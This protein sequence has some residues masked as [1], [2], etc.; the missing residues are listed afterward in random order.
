MGLFDFVVDAGKKLGL[1][2]GGSG[3]ANPAK[4]EATASASLIKEIQKHGLEVRD[5]GVQFQ[6]SVAVVTGEVDT[7]EV[8][9]KVILVVGNVEGVAQVEDRLTVVNPQPQAVFHT[10]GGVTRS[11]R[12][13]GLLRERYEVAGH[14]EANRPMLTDP[15][16][17]LSGTI[18][19]HLL[20]L[21]SIKPMMFVA[22]ATGL[23][24]RRDDESMRGHR[25][26][27]ATPKTG[28]SRRRPSGGG[29]GAGDLFVAPRP[30][31]PKPPPQTSSVLWTGALSWRFHKYTNN[32]VRGKW[33]R[34][35][36]WRCPSPSRSYRIVLS[37]G[38]EGRV[39]SSR[40]KVH[41]TVFL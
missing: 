1:V 10:V 19:A 8:G 33:H 16:Q 21:H 9:E 23:G 15:E 18:V 2:G 12:S 40:P 6:D 34:G 3:K 27:G 41:V 22:S 20:V 36:L 35:T 31:L 14:F 25:R 30:H 17:N 26:G 4:I 39:A 37:P 13:Q 7:Q 28:A 11:P 29:G 5:L 32:S 38:R 24:C